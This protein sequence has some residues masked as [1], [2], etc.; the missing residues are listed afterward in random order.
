MASVIES[1]N[2][3]EQARADAVEWAR[4]NISDESRLADFGAGHNRGWGDCIRTLKAQGLLKLTDTV[5]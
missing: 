2:W 3:G 1:I 4:I 5:D